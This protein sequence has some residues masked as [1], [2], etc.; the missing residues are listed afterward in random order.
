MH[1]LLRRV[2]PTRVA[3]YLKFVFNFILNFV[4][5]ISFEF[6][7]ISIEFY[8]QCR[9]QFC[10]QFHLTNFIWFFFNFVS[11]SCEFCSQSHF[12]FC[13]QIHLDFI[14]NVVFNFICWILFDFFHFCLNFV[15][16]VIFKFIWITTVVFNFVW[17]I[18][19]SIQSLYYVRD[20]TNKK[21]NRYRAYEIDTFSIGRKYETNSN[22]YREIP[23]L[24][25]NV[26]HNFHT[27]FSLPHFC[28]YG[29]RFLSKSFSM[30]LMFIRLVNSD[31]S[32]NRLTSS[33]LSSTFS[34]PTIFC[35][36]ETTTYFPVSGSST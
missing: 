6:F 32:L 24:I 34:T 35:F 23:K 4:W 28:I 33:S 12:E 13:F 26:I 11:I 5:W 27:N 25:W 15:L 21:L 17:W 20:K 2:R 14:F 19:F 1:G 10:F 30:C 3:S 8:F 16:H 18:L 29:I 31:I 22:P 9:F 36:V 7:S